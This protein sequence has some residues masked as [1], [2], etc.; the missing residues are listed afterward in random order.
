QRMDVGHRVCAGFEDGGLVGG[1][2]EAGVEVIEAA[3]RN[4]AAVE[5]YEAGEVFGFGAQ[6][7]GDPC[8]HA[9]PA[10]RA[11]AG[12]EEVVGGGVLGKVGSHGADEGEVIGARGDVGEE[13]GDGQAGFAVVFEL[14]GGAQGGAVV[15]ELGGLHFHFEVLAVLFGE[16][17]F[18]VKGVHGTYAS[19]HVEED[20]VAGA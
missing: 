4:Q 14:P 8:A 12:V 3:R 20:D 16:Q 7:V 6:A 11:R 15:V 13:I 19:I 17:R 1:G 18:G 9:G 2:E 10:L 5:D